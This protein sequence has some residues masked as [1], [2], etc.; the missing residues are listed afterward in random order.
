MK[1]AACSR[2][3]APACASSA[4]GSLQIARFVHA[5]SATGG[6]RGQGLLLQRA[7]TSAVSVCGVAQRPARR[8]HNPEAAGSN[9]ATAP[10]PI[11]GSSGSRGSGNRSEPGTDRG[12]A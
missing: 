4:P 6:R 3:Q 8:A 7:H 9:P 11:D 12:R 2:P 1:P 10:T 5:S